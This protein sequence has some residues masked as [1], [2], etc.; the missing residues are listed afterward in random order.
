MQWPPR[1]ERQP[2]DYIPAAVRREVYERDGGSCAYVSEQDRRCRS[3]LRLEYQHIVPLACGVA[4]GYKRGESEHAVGIAVEQLPHGGDL[5]SLL[6]TSF[7][8]LGGGS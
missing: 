1:P 8:I 6:R 5:Q 3:T 7:Q 4:L 2:P